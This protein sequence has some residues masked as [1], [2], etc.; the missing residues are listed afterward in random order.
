MKSAL[1]FT[2]V[3]M[4]TLAA[5]LFSLLDAGTKYLG[6]ILSVGAILWC[7]YLI[8]TCVMAAT[9][10]RTRGST[11]FHTTHL[12]FQLLRGVL[13]V[14]LSVLTYYSLR[15]MPLAEFTAIMMLTPIIVTAWSSWLSKEQLG[16]LRWALLWVG[17]AGTLV[18]IRPGSGL[19]GAEVILPLLGTVVSAAYSMITSRLAVLENP[20]TTQFYTSITGLSLVTPLILLQVTG[21]P[22][23]FADLS[24][25]QL[26]AL[27]GVGLVGT[28]GHLVLVMAFSRA[29]ATALMPFTYTQIGF[30]ALIS[31]MLFQ[32]A[33]DF[34]AW[35]GMSMITASSC[36][37]A[38]FGIQSHR[39]AQ[40]HS[41]STED[42]DRSCVPTCGLQGPTLISKTN[43]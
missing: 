3:G 8:Q 34:W 20:N 28:G 19:F 2:A 30:A 29:H 31:W 26:L 9:L 16:L 13:L 14:T 35:A 17:F 7:R 38:W 39:L 33:P 43:E 12:R 40:S 6:G 1:S 15:H 36:A 5:L 25:W 10:I 23:I 11:G 27:L 21:L 24:A 18:V 37:T 41:K 4:I 42:R 32:H 22:A